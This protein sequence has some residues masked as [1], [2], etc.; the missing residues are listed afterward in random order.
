M[1][2]A[3]KSTKRQQ[4]D[5]GGMEAGRRS[6]ADYV[7][8]TLRREILTLELEPVS[9]LDETSLSERFGLSRTPVREALVRL[10]SEGLVTSL[11]NRGAIVAPLDLSHTSAYFEALTLLQRVTTRLAARHHTPQGLTAIQGYQERFAEAVLGSDVF[12]MIELNR[13]FHV[14]I[15]ET[16]RNPYFTHAYTRV[17]DEGKR[18]L[19]LYYASFHDQLPHVYV[20]EHDQIIV[21]IKERDEE[22]ADKLA[23]QHA[24]QVVRQIQ[25]LLTSDLGRTIG[26]EPTS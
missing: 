10:T 12:N 14:A 2:R 24:D 25:S 23:C 15:A 7:Y 4:G 13:E 9:P 18:M 5:S 16:G 22:Q 8:E 11:P 1:N 6:G 21:A 26:L 20:E 3:R 19:R 17:L